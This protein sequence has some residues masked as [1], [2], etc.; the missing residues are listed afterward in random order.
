MEGVKVPDQ[1]MEYDPF[2]DRVDERNTTLFRSCTVAVG[3]GTEVVYESISEKSGGVWYTTP[4]SE[5]AT[6]TSLVVRNP[7][8]YSSLMVPFVTIWCMARMNSGE[9]AS[10]FFSRMNRIAS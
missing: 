5:S 8:P 7:P 3:K 2:D 6:T 10:S 1:V 9:R 4:D